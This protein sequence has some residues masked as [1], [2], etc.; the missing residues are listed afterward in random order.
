MFRKKL[1][2]PPTVPAPAP[3]PAA[4]DRITSVL[5]VGI[6]WNGNLGGSGGVRIEGT[7]EGDIAMRGLLVVGETGRVTCQCM[8]ANTVIVAGAVKGDITAERLEIRSTGKVWGNVVTVSFSTEEGAFLRGQITMEDKVD[9]GVSAGAEPNPE[10][11]PA[12][13]A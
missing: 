4:I 7:F 13:K 11:E 10:A 9:I 6:N 3:S 12:E 1:A 2:A 8:R 5:S